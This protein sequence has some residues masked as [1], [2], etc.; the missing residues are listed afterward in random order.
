VTNNKRRVLHLKIDKIQYDILR[1]HAV[2]EKISLPKIVRGVLDQFIKMKHGQ[3][4]RTDIL[5]CMRFSL[6][7]YEQLEAAADKEGKS[8]DEFVSVVVHKAI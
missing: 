1:E 8:I 6:K 4:P 7:T 3:I 5:V 2:S